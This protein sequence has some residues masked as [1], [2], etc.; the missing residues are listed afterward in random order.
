MIMA[1]ILFFAILAGYLFFRLWG[2]L[3]ERTGF[4]KPQDMND[5]EIAPK[6]GDNVVPLP[7][8]L[9]SKAAA[10]DEESVEPLWND[11]RLIQE[12]EKDFNVDTFLENV[13]SAFIIITQAFVEGDKETLRSLLTDKTYQQ[14]CKVI[15]DRQSKEHR[16]T[17]EI[18][19][20]IEVA[21]HDVKT[22]GK[23]ADMTVK[24]MSNQRFITYDK[25]GE[26][27]DNPEEIANKMVNYWTFTRTL[28]ADDP[29][30]HLSQT[31]VDA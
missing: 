15:D 28:G 29:V 25:K 22:L 20:R 27:L 23:K 7:S 18:I 4:E 2:V 8:R 21:L 6:A 12:K 19:G 16:T 26:I 3:G 17:N 13:T 31:R 5:A 10:L 24:I 14:F 1:E 11:L 9:S 30:W